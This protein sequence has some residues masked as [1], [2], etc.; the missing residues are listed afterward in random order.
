MKNF[1][2]FKVETWLGALFVL[3]FAGF[4]LGLFFLSMKNFDTELSVNTTEAHLTSLQVSNQERTMM[5][6][7][8]ERNKISIPSDTDKIRYLLSKYP[9][10]PW[11]Q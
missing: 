5:A 6:V 3:G 10:R 9:D 4:F 1:R 7:W 2:T 11:L 8:V